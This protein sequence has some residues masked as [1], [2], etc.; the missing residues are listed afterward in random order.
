M[1]YGVHQYGSTTYYSINSAVD[2]VVLSP[3]IRQ[4]GARG[5]KGVTDDKQPDILAADVMQKLVKLLDRSN[6][7]SKMTTIG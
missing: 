6:S 5:A 1:S 2:G 4:Q 7:P 3:D